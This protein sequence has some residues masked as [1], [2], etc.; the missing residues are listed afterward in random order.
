MIPYAFVAIIMTSINSVAENVIA[1]IK[2]AI[3]KIKESKV[4]EHK[5]FI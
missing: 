5:T 4:A 1:D 2:E 3:P